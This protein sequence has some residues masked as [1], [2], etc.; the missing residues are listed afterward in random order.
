MP[1]PWIRNM[2]VPPRSTILVK[3]PGLD[4]KAFAGDTALIG[5]G[6]PSENGLAPLDLEKALRDA[7]EAA[8][9]PDRVGVFLPKGSNHEL[10]PLPRLASLALLA[11]RSGPLYIPWRALSLAGVESASFLLVFPEEGDPE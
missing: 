9:I 7:L 3:R 8:G 5:G 2:S 6:T 11:R 10:K 4:G 1:A